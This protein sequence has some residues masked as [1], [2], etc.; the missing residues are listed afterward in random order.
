MRQ[1]VRFG[2]LIVILTG[3]GIGCDGV[4]G[5]GAA[6]SPSAAA[7]PT[8][9]APDTYHR[10]VSVPGGTR[11][12]AVVVCE[13][14]T[15]GQLDAEGKQLAVVDDK[16]QPV[17][18]RVLQVGPGDYCRVAFE[19]ATRATIYQIHYGAGAQ[20][21]T[22]PPWGTDAGLLVE[23]RTFRPCDM[24]NVE[25]LRQ[26]MAGAERIGRDYVPGVFHR[27]NPCSS[28]P[29]GFF[30]HYRGKIRIPVAGLYKFFT[31]SQDASFLLIDGKQVVA[32]PG[33]HGPVGDARFAGEARL[34]EGLHE[35]E[36]LHAAAGVEACMVAAWL[37]P[38][39][40]KPEPIPPEAFGSD[41]VARLAAPGPWYKTERPVY[42]I[43]VRIAGEA[44][45]DEAQPPL[46]RVQFRSLSG[47]SASTNTRGVW[48]FGDGQTSTQPQPTHIYLRPGIYRVK[49]HVRGEPETLAA[50]NRVAITRAS[51]SEDPEAP[52]DQL[53][54][55]LPVIEG[56]EIKTLD[57]QSMLQ[58]V[59][60]EL[61]AGRVAAAAKALKEWYQ[62]RAAQV[63]D[64]AV[65]EM[66]RPVC[67]IL[68]DE[69]ERTGEALEIWKL[70][71][72]SASAGPIRAEC[73]VEAADLALNDLLRID[74]ARTLLDEATP[75]LVSA[76]GNGAVSRLHR[77][78][79]DWHA[80]K[81]DGQAARESY[82]KARAAQPGGRSVVEQEARRGALSRST[83]AFL[84]EK[85]APRSIRTLREWQENYPADRAG[86]EFS[87]LLARY[88]LQRGQPERALFVVDQLITTQPDSPFADQLIWLA[89]QACDARK[90]PERARAYARTL[91]TDYP[92]SPLVP[93]AREKLEKHPVRDDDQPK[94]AATDRR[95][96]ASKDAEKKQ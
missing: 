45:Y 92:G 60:V 68:R 77:V 71:A 8:G 47:A 49:Y 66:A 9:A 64:T 96:D 67:A 48:D 52:G 38:G 36:Y 73:Q 37:R 3:F 39:S 25:S 89:A 58:M 13:F 57:A 1:G 51:P 81:G 18:W 17:P 2:S 76:S 94:A 6:E 40:E 31:S 79:G 88:W 63:D 33:Y 22:N 61:F 14:F 5:Q 84:R 42:D 65:L 75:A 29:A 34:N 4:H 54:E 86:G 70:A 15:H 28:E 10:R 59:R 90:Q 87:L 85:N 7:K 95:A 80:A 83:E 23:V 91:V 27:S 43:A 69:V 12:P 44:A 74:E 62:T 35:F 21:W 24:Q 11:R 19:P 26:A 41:R 55:Y 82:A 16:K 72:A 53:T 93:Q 50:V 20:L 56:Y 46:V 32:W 78:W 30:S